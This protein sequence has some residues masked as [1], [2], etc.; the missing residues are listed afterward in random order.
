MSEDPVLA[1]I[2][3]LRAAMM[4]RMDRLDAT[5]ERIR[6][7]MERQRRQRRTAA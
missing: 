5:I 2:A 1:A 7:D 4:A 6:A 3:E